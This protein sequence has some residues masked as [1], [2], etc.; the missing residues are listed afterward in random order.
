MNL[1]L[2]DVVELVCPMGDAIREA[3]Y[4]LGQEVVDISLCESDCV[5][6]SGLPEIKE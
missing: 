3:A 4:S 1:E 6:L 2:V 5:D